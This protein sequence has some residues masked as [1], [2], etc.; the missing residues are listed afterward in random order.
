M[1]EYSGWV[2]YKVAR[3]ILTDNMTFEQRPEVSE[4]LNL[5][6]IQGKSIPSGRKSTGKPSEVGPL[7]PL[8]YFKCGLGAQHIT[9][10]KSL[11]DFGI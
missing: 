10:V 4:S 3:K 8:K 5:T 7:I 11:Y 6:D 9:I 1:W 2:F